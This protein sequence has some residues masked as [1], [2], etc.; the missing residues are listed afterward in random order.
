MP[1]MEK[2]IKLYSNYSICKKIVTLSLIT[3]TFV[4]VNL[5]SCKA[6]IIT[7]ESDKE[8]NSE[9][10]IDKFLHTT[11]SLSGS[12]GLLT[13][14][15]PDINSNVKL[16]ITY[17]GGI[18]KNDLT[19]NNQNYRCSKNEHFTGVFYNI[20]PNLE[21]STIHLR[22]NRSINPYLA[23]LK[24]EEN[25]TGFGIKYSTKNFE[26]DICAG[27]IFA[28]MSSEEISRADLTQIELLRCIYITLSE[29]I[30]KNIYG[31]LH[32]KE[33]FTKNQ[34]IILDNNVK[35]HRDVKNFLTS[36]IGLE[37][38]PKGKFYSVFLEAKFTNYRD[39]FKDDATR[40]TLNAG[41][42]L[43]NDKVNAEFYGVSLQNEPFLM[44]GSS[45]AF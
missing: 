5:H 9:K 33:S 10:H 37:Y 42:R 17:K 39:I 45:I 25:Y 19:I 44:L 13:I 16:G 27:F 11:I 36:G 31:Y 38:A 41:I 26:Q 2:F 30:F 7:F 34:K 22:S 43:G 20:K 1:V 29:E 28:P 6:Q 4:I 23:Q 24:F 12:T 14:P 32:L 35:L 40:F 3:L 8:D 21:F 18:S 15:T